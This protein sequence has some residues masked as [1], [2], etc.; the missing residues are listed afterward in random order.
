MYLYHVC[1]YVSCTYKYMY[2]CTYIPW[3]WNK[4]KVKSLHHVQLFATPWTVAYQA[5]SS[6]EFSRQEYWS[7]LPFAS[8]EDLPDPGIEQASD[9]A[10]A[11]RFSTPEPPGDVF[12]TENF[13]TPYGRCPFFRQTNSTE[14]PPHRGMYVSETT[15]TS[16]PTR[17][18]QWELPIRAL[19]SPGQ[20]IRLFPELEAL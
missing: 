1:V 11:G 6:M 10:L 3:T 5:L 18:P 13:K 17:R 14:S 8:P 4:V 19:R 2:I 12:T 15:G 9:P 20:P 7:G 16:T